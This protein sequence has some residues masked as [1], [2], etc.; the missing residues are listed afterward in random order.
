LDVYQ[1][2]EGL[3][4]PMYDLVLR[5]PDFEQWGLRTQIRK[6]CRGIR[7]VIAEGYGRR[8]TPKEFCRFLSFGVGSANE[9]EAHLRAARILEYIA[10]QETNEYV[11][12][13]RIVGKQLTS[14]IKIGSGRMVTE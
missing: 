5:F 13:Y 7:A 2:S 12:E 3:I 14:L 1:R 8:S 9:M 10:E 6:A 11:G 4:K